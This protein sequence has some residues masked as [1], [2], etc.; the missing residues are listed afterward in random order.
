MAT[1]TNAAAHAKYTF[2][3][4]QLEFFDIRYA[5]AAQSSPPT[6]AN[7]A[8]IEKLPKK[9]W[10]KRNPDAATKPTNQAEMRRKA[11]TAV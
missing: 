8:A 4:A 7:V 3:G 9:T 6:P 1:P 10:L 11:D 5:K 2:A